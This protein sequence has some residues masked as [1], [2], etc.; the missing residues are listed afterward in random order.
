MSDVTPLVLIRC[1]A[2]LAIVSPYLL[3]PR[4]QLIL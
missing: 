2:G 3:F 4:L 1:V